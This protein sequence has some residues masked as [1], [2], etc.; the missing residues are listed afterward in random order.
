M[1]IRFISSLCAFSVCAALA[2][3]DQPQWGE[4][5]SRNMVSDETGLPESFDP[6]TGKNVKWSVPLGTQSY[7]TPIIAAGRVFIG[8]NNE[9]PRNPKHKDDC[10]VLLCLDEKDGAL[11][12]QLVV[13]KIE[14]GDPFKDWPKTGMVSPPTIEGGRV[15]TVTNRGEAVCLDLAGMANG[16]DGPYVD[17]GKHMAVAGQSPHEVCPTDADILW[18][19]DMV[20]GAGIY[21]HD[22][23]HCSVL[24]DGPFLYINT[25]NGVDNTHRKI[26]CPNAPS[27]VVLDKATGKFLARDEEMIAPN[28]PH[29]QWSSP[30]LGEVHGQKL[31]FLGGANGICYAFEALQSAPPE[32]Q[33]QKLRRVWSFDC[34]PAAPK[35]EIHKYQGNK[36]EGPSQIT[37]M[38]VFYKNRVYVAAGGDVWQ[39]K[40]SAWLKCI[41]ASRSGEITK[42]GELWSYPIPAICISTP[43]IRDGLVYIS[44][45][46]NKVHCVD[47]ETGQ[48]YWVHDAQ[49]PLWASCLVADGKVFIGTR[50][51]TFWILAAGKELKVLCSVRLDGEISGTATAANGVVYVATMKRLYALKK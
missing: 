17:E 24:L 28:I 33:V 39:G 29:A 14:G 8:T 2:A 46:S 47:A 11:V 5:H 6:A 50:A 34:D 45:C 49:G 30:A 31:I 23:Q 15:Y 20:A 40:R 48:V 12:W 37:G 41:D 42:T 43:A 18:L 22:A 44:D 26:R 19:F 16:N 25:S 36:R 9:P 21:T 10:G 13:P 51:G 3:N 27:L 35:Q 32:G 7:G 1:D 4:R 38:P